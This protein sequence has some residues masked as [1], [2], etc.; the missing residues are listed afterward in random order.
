MKRLMTLAWGWGSPRLMMKFFFFVFYFNFHFFSSIWFYVREVKWRKHADDTSKLASQVLLRITRTFVC[1]NVELNKS[2]SV[3]KW[4][5]YSASFEV[6]WEPTDADNLRVRVIKALHS[7]AQQ[8]R[9]CWSKN[10]RKWHLCRTHNFT[11]QEY[12]NSFIIQLAS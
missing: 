9:R 8:I 12:Q 3:E 4:S 6:W 2:W 1:C 5:N 10:S 7:F 11:V